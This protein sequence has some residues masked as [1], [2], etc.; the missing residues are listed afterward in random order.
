ML[1]G[2]FLLLDSYVKGKSKLSLT[3]MKQKPSEKVIAISRNNMKFEYEFYNFIKE[4]F[5]K[6]KR[7][8]GI[9]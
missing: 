5:H 3:R 6:L 2:I 4:R 7:S 1:N 9:K 8:L